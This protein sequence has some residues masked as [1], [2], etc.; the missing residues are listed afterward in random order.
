MEGLVRRTEGL[1]PAVATPLDLARA[2]A[3]LA[4]R[5]QAVRSA[6][7]RWH[8]ASAELVRLL[9]LDAA[10]IVEPM[11]PPDLRLTLVPPTVPVDELIPVGLTNRPELAA[12]Q[13]LVQ[14]TLYRLRA[15]KLRP[16]MPSVLVRGASTPVT[17][18]LAGGYFGGGLNR[19]LSHFGARGDFDVQV[20]W[21]LQNLGFGNRAAVRQQQS[22]NRLALLELFRIQDRVAAEVAAAHAQ[23]LSAAGRVGDAERGVKEAAESVRLH[24]QGLYQTRQPGAPGPASLL[25]RPQEAV[26][27]VQALSLAYGDYYAAAADYNRAQFRLYRALGR[28]ARALADIFGPPAPACLSAP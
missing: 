17:G 19:T 1:V 6:Y 23:L 9:R 16:L 25:V 4:R 12:Q 11:E 2:R 3:E 26:A 8:L 10:A 15:E 14:A 5:Q 20:L 27:A 21:E 13:A 28:P 7:E 24:L 22:Q 18:T